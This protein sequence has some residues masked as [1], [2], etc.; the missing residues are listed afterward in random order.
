MHNEARI[1]Q[2]V[3]AGWDMVVVDEA[4]HLGWSPA[5]AS[6]EYLAIER[7]ARVSPGLLLLT[8]TP[9]QLGVASHFARLRLLDPDRLPGSRSVHWPR[10]TPTASVARIVG[11]LK[12][13][14]NCECRRSDG[15]SPQFSG[16]E[17][18]GR[19]AA[20]AMMRSRVR[21][22]SSR[23]LDSARNRARHVPQ[24]ARH[25]CRLSL[26]RRAPLSASGERPARHKALAESGPAT[27]PRTSVVTRDID[28]RPRSA[29]RLAGLAAAVARRVRRC[30]SSAA[31]GR[32][33]MAIESA[34]K[35]RTTAPVAAFHE[36]LTLVQ[37]DRGAA[38]FADPDGARLL[39]LLGD[40]QRG[41]QFPVRASPRAVR[42]PA[43]SGDCSN[44]GSA[45]SIASASARRFRFMCRDSG[46]AS[47]G[48]GAVVSRGPHAFE[49]HLPGAS[50]LLRA[51]RA[52]T[53]GT[54]PLAFARIAGHP[55][56]NWI[57][58]SLSVQEARRRGGRQARTGPRPVARMELLPSGP[59]GA[60]HR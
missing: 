59:V 17:Q 10:A 27:S 34:L 47:R 38:C 1:D 58:F 19:C 40:R 8:A 16:S 60:H 12:E 30:C 29:H 44:S 57:D 2:A 21:S 43:G 55:R 20:I 15:T 36:G 23:L 24:Y 45:G 9:E 54:S 52:T 3:A 39:D 46:R 53:C 18:Q 33:A 32:K 6:A 51:L 50:E 37:R 42:S 22:G 48:A 25:D 5:S 14:A 7:L 28:L 41:A 11:L 49:E 4:H 13:A 35:H 26:T 31:R 56:R